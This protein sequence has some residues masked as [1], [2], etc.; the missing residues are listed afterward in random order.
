MSGDLRS[1]QDGT[2]ERDLR[3]TIDAD[4]GDV[5]ARVA[6]ARLL[7]ALGREDEALSQY[8]F[9]LTLNADHSEA[10]HEVVLLSRAQASRQGS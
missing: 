3:A 9:V 1:E 2:A 8:R 7:R 4:P 6:Y 5:H 10:R